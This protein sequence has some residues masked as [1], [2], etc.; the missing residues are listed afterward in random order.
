MAAISDLEALLAEVLALVADVL[1][2]DAAVLAVFMAALAFV[3]DALAEDAEEAAAVAL[4][5]ADVLYSEA[6]SFE[7]LAEAALLAAEDALPLAEVAEE[8]DSCAFTLLYKAHERLLCVF[9]VVLSV[10]ADPSGDPVDSAHFLEYW[11]DTSDAL[12][13]EALLLADIAALDALAFAL[14]SDVAEAVSE[15]LAFVS[16]ALA[17]VADLP[18]LDA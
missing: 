5:L 18:A 12:A 7:S 4:P 10:S 2:D 13:L 9:P 3:A 1:A 15:L 6:L 16:L 11:L 8:A 17:A 14:A